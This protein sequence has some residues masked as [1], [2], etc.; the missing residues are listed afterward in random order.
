MAW[1][2]SRE[3]ATARVSRRTSRSIWS[4]GITSRKTGARSW[5]R[6]RAWPT[7]RPG[8]TGVPRSSTLGLLPEPALDESGKRVESGLG[9][10]A[11]GRELEHGAHGGREEQHAQDRLAVHGPPLPAHR[12]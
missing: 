8:E 7:A 3:A 11:L 2:C 5:S 10:V 4:G 9:V 1:S 6:I 12:D